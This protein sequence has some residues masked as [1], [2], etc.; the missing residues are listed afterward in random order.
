MIVMDT[1]DLTGQLSLLNDSSDGVKTL[2]LYDFQRRGIIDGRVL[3]R[4]GRRNVVY[5]APTGAGKTIISV[6]LL[7]VLRR[8][9]LNALFICDRK[10]LVRQTRNRLWEYGVD[11]GLLWADQTEDLHKPITVCSVQTMSSKKHKRAALQL[12]KRADL[13]IIDE[14]HTNYAA[15]FK[16]LDEVNHGKTKANRKRVIGLTATPFRKGMGNIYDG[17]VN[18]ATTNELI[19]K[20]SIV[21]LEVYL[22]KPSSRIDMKDAPTNYAGEWDESVVDERTNTDV[23]GNVLVE[24][25]RHTN[26][27]FG[28]PVKTLLFS[29]S[30]K[31]GEEF[32][33]LFQEAGYNFQQ[34]TAYTSDEE[35]DRLI[36]EFEKPN[37]E[38]IG[39]ISVDMLAKGF[40]VPDVLCII[41]CRPYRKSFAGH[42]QQIGRVMRNAPG[43][44]FG[45]FLDHAQNWPGWLEDTV[46]LFEHGVDSLD[47]DFVTK[48]FQRKEEQEV[49]EIVC[50]EC[51]YVMHPGDRSCPSCGAERWAGASAPGHVDGHME[52][53]DL[54]SILNGTEAKPKNA[55]DVSAQWADRKWWAWENICRVAA[56]KR[57]TREQAVMFAFAQYKQMFKEPAL[58]GMN[59]KVDNQEPD[60]QVGMIVDMQYHDFLRKLHTEKKYKRGRFA[61][62]GK[63]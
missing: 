18:I 51:S 33:R 42:I 53:L 43:K 15:L 49:R 2:E 11:H 24:W 26:D 10:T 60:A 16:M 23:I 32:A 7:N 3:F 12:M 61:K 30:I 48:K 54:E 6:H 25:V 4:K 63:K 38:I 39:L 19:K 5:Y 58:Y 20:G 57:P 40:D 17:I 27:Y 14:C 52:Y 22:G 1:D 45:L 8:N 44:T 36:T 37:S 21:R 55:P 41:G 59:Y 56:R 9:K 35:K 13:I 47:S 50:P 62:K 29:A 31:K 46:W 34:V 28:G